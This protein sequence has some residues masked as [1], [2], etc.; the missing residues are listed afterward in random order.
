MVEWLELEEEMWCESRGS[1]QEPAVTMVDRGLLF[2]RRAA[3]SDEWLAGKLEAWATEARELAQKWRGAHIA[4]RR[5]RSAAMQRGFLGAWRVRASGLWREAA[6]RHFTL[7]ALTT[8]AGDTFPQHARV[9]ALATHW[10]GLLAWVLYLFHVRSEVCCDDLRTFVGCSTDPDELCF[11]GYPTC[12]QIRDSYPHGGFQCGA[13]PDPADSLEQLAV[14]VVAVLMAWP[15]RCVLAA[16]HRTAAQARR[17]VDTAWLRRGAPLRGAFD[18]TQTWRRATAVD[19][20]SFID[21]CAH[22]CSHLSSYRITS[23]FHSSASSPL[24]LSA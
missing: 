4:Q 13:F 12:A 15:V 21:R 5:R 14:V 17:P 11:G 3:R 18:H 20:T 24:A 8:P 9:T 19:G 16:L 23:Y 2:V 10:L 1:G 7:R 22:A 6:R